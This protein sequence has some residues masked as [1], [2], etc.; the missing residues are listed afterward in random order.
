V[1]RDA[2]KMLESVA[3]SVRGLRVKRSD[4]EALKRAVMR[5]YS[6]AQRQMQRACNDGSPS[7]FHQWRK[8]VK[9]LWYHLRL[10]SRRAPGF[11]RHAAQLERL[12]DLL[13][14]EH[15]LQVLHT[16][17]S[18]RRLVPGRQELASLTALAEQRQQRLRRTALLA[19]GR[20]FAETPEKFVRTGFGRS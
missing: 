16:Y 1:A 3:D 18:R 20:V 5:A 10:L 13:G 2:R 17:V 6:R 15:N 14:R 11:R 12:A 8:R 4:D 7:R 19:G 9:T